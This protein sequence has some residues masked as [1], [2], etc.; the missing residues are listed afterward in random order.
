MS[1]GTTNP[2]IATAIS[3]LGDTQYHVIGIPWVD[4]SNLT[5]IEDELE[6]R[7]GPL[8]QLEGQAFAAEDDSQ[9]NLQSLGNGRNSQFLSIIEAKDS[10]SPPWEYASSAAALVAFHGSIDPGRPFQTLEMK[11]I[12]APALADRF[13]L[14]ARNTLLFNSISTTK[15]AP[16]GGVLIERLITTRDKNSLGADDF[17]MLDV[18]VMLTLSFIRFDLRTHLQNRFPRHKLADDGTR[19]APGQAVV[20]P[21]KIRAEIIAKFR[22]W[23]EI[24][25]VEN[26]EQF[27]A[28]LIVERN[29]SDPNRVDILMPPDLINQLRVT[30]AQ[31]QFI[32]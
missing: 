32:T 4:A 22:Q 26:A 21:G 8:V 1:G 6:S 27:K 28:D 16:G 18:N 23:E 13:N 29:I 10:P 17:S 9:S 2:D 3:G 19:F 25:L 12:K 30:A 14:S 31:V 15:I 7:W 20:T 24:A 11:G 5:K